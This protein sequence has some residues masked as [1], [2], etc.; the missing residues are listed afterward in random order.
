M[1]RVDSQMVRDA[2]EKNRHH[3]TM[4]PLPRFTVRVMG[5]AGQPQTHYVAFRSLG[6]P[7]I[8]KFVTEWCDRNCVGK[9]YVGHKRAVHFDLEEDALLFWMTFR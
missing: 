6:K 2:G 7:E 9:R 1:I 3:H 5:I 4:Q 8:R